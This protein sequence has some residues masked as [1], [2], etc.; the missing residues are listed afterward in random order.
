MRKTLATLLLLSLLVVAMF[1]FAGP[2]FASRADKGS[3]DHPGNH[4]ACGGGKG[5]GKDGGT[6]TENCTAEGY[7]LVNVNG[8]LQCVFVGVS[9]GDV[10]I[11]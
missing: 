8:V 7:G 10:S 11:L 5:G 2:A 9:V 6:T 3:C 1:A 4:A